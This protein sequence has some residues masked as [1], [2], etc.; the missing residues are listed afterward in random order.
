MKALVTALLFGSTLALSACGSRQV[1]VSTGAQTQPEVSINLTN[2]TGSQLNV[3]V[4]HGG[5]RIFVGQVSSNST[6][7]LPVANVPAG[8]VVRLEASTVTSTPRTYSRD[9]VTL[10]GTYNWQVP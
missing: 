4:V 5:Q 10:N 3:Y 7:M 8:S 6:Q 1:E 2:N 9:T